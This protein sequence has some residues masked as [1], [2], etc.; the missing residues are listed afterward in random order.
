MR[1]EVSLST[2]QPVA[3]AGALVAPPASVVHRV[4]AWI[5][6]DFGLVA[7]FTAALAVLVAAYGGSFKWTEGPVII[8][9]GI[10]AGL[11]LARLAWRGRAI[12]LN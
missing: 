8:S 1:A 5:G 2:A 6:P 12:A 10:A 3:R 4:M 9:A 11:M 7:G